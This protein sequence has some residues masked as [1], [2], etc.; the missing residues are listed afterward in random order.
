MCALLAIRICYFCNE[1]GRP[2]QTHVQFSTRLRFFSTSTIKIHSFLCPKFRS[3]L[4]SSWQ[5]HNTH[6]PPEDISHD[7]SKPLAP[8]GASHPHYCYLSPIHLRAAAHHT[9]FNTVK[10]Y[11]DNRPLQRCRLHCTLVSSGIVAGTKV[12]SS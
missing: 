4:T 6:P 11:P 2:S 7:R 12:E 10:T 1:R 9:L 3:K 8:R 5:S